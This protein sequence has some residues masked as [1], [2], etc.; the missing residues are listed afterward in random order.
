MGSYICEFHERNEHKQGSR[1]TI[2]AMTRNEEFEI[3]DEIP[4]EVEE[5]LRLQDEALALLERLRS[6]E[7]YAKPAVKDEGGGRR[8]FRRWPMPAG[9]SV[10][11]HDGLQWRPID[12]IDM[13]VGGARI[14]NLPG[15]VVGPAPARLKAP[16]LGG[17]IL[18]L[19]DVMW[20]DVRDHKAGLRFEFSDLEERDLWSGALIDALLAQYAQA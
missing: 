10:E 6:E 2:G 8:D 14:A 1:G 12:C 18:V 20:K 9:V 5:A 17:A 7:P 15:W 13:G 19:S 3:P 4:D 16:G 11:L